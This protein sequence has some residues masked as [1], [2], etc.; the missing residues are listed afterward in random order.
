MFF[1]QA[2]PIA[3]ILMSCK[4]ESLYTLALKKVL[5]IFEERFPGLQCL[6]SLMISDFEQPILKSM[7]TVFPSGKSRGCWFHFAQVRIVI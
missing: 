3:Y 1:S 2:F 4:T 5:E 6:P 7:E